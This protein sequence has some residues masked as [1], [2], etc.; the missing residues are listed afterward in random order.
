[1]HAQREHT[2]G[3]VGLAAREI[4]ARAPPAGEVLV[5]VVPVLVFR[6]AHVEVPDLL[7]IALHIVDELAQVLA[8]LDARVEVGAAVQVCGRAEAA[9]IRRLEHV[10]LHANALTL[11][12]P[13]LDTVARS[14]GKDAYVAQYFHVALDAEVRAGDAADR[15]VGAQAV[16]LAGDAFDRADRVPRS[17]SCRLA[18]H[19]LVCPLAHSAS[20]A[21]VVYQYISEHTS[22]S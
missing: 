3:A 6:A 21:I 19:R 16:R 20:R 11:L 18:W 17:E 8:A 12:H 10:R 15:F 4:S 2:V 13:T 9:L 22:E 7:L 14:T 5:V 1:M